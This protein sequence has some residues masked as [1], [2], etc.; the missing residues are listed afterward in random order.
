MLLKDLLR[1]VKE[2]KVTGADDVEVKGIVYDSREVEAGSLFMCLP[3]TQT[4]GHKFIGKAISRGAVAVVTDRDT[5]VYWNCTI[6]KTSEVGKVLSKVAGNFY[7]NPS[8]QLRLIGVTG[9]NGKTTTTH[10]IDKLMRGNERIETGLIGTIGCKVGEE[11]RPVPATT[12][13]ATVLHKIFREMV[14]R[15]IFYCTME[16]SSHALAL[17]RVDDC[18]F[19]IAVLTNITE[20]HLDFHKNFA[21]YLQAKAKLFL[22]LS[23]KEGNYIV[24]NNDDNNA[25]YIKERSSP[26]ILTYGI[27]KAADVRGGNI[28]I[29]SSGA[30]FTVYSW[31][32][33]FS[34]DLKIT[35]SF[36]VYNALAAITVALKENI[37]PS[38]I[39]NVLESVTGVPGR[40]EKVDL[41][42]DFTVIVDYA[43][44][45][46][47]LENVLSTAR[48]FCQGNLI[49]VFGCGGD[50]DRSKRS[51]MGNIALK[52]S[53][54]AIIT[55][56]NPRTESPF[57]IKADIL[58]GIDHNSYRGKYETILDREEAIKAAINRARATDVVL[59]AGK[60]HETYQIFDDKTIDFDD[61]EMARRYLLKRQV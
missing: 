18:D 16:V 41:G 54:Y 3:G 10:L 45:P 35:G 52:Y 9:T 48:R 29:T 17:H 60:G 25:L 57:R 15:K 11:N 36:N 61:R 12:P 4:D 19:N 33:E 2:I 24:I 47:G 38:V 22:N 6:I 14:D 56:D 37:S 31:Q 53:D 40:F 32:K 30:T 50:R 58:S 59:I 34:L 8:R 46:D 20:D 5:D 13:E 27:K 28:S 43:H 51:L 49:T 55:N 44:T 26:E 7:L 39:K 1:G 42:Q 21:T 23:E